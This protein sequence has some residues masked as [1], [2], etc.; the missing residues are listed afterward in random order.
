MNDPKMRV[1]LS[2][3]RAQG[4][5]ALL[6]LLLL[7]LLPSALRAQVGSASLSGVVQDATGAIISGASVIAHNDATGQERK[8]TSNSSGGFTFSA[9]PSGDY[10]ITASEKGFSSSTVKAVH[11]DPGA[12]KALNGIQLEA[13]NVSTSVEVNTEAAGIPLDSGELSSTI[14]AKDLEHLSTVGR[15]AQELEKTLPGF[16]IRSLSNTNSAPDFTIVTIGSPTPYSSNGAPVAGITLK[17]DGAV[18]TDAGNFGANL[19]NINDSFVSE[20]NVQTSNFGVD[21]SNGPVV[22]SAVTKPG[23]SAYHG[24]VYTFARYSALNANDWLSNN[25]GLARPDDRFIYPGG[26]VSGPIPHTKKLTFFAGAEYDAQRNVYA[27]GNSGSAIIHALVPTQAMRNG[28]F[29]Q[30]SLQSYL[31]PNYNN[32]GDINVMPTVGDNGTALANGNLAPYL[33][34]QTM[35]LVNYLLPLPNRPG[36]ATGADGYNW[37][38]QNLVNNNISQYVGRVDYAISPRNTFFARYNFE[39]GKQGQPQVPYYSPQPGNVLGSVNSPGY[40]LEQR[41]SVHS[42]AANYVTIFSPTATNEAFAAL[43]YS[44]TAFV[45]RSNTAV[46]AATAGFGYSAAFANGTT[47]VPQLGTYAAV[48]GLPLALTPDFSVIGLGNTVFQPNVG[49]NFTKVYGKHTVKVGF[50]LQRTSGDGTQTGPNNDTNGVIQNYYFGAAGAEF[51]GYKGTY[52]NGSPAYDGT[53]HYNSG[54]WLG[55]FFEGHIQDYHQISGNP[56]ENLY[57]WTT[58]FYGQDSWRVNKTLLVTG[59]IRFSRMSAWTDRHN[60]GAAVFD[61]SLVNT[62]QSPTTNPYPGLT[63]HAQNSAIQN[64]GTGTPGI[65]V[66]PRVGFAWDVFGTAKTVVRGGYGVYRFHDAT[67]DVQNAF[68]QANGVRTL[69]LQ[70]F[71]GNTLAGIGTL[72]LNPA[73]YG[74]AGGTETSIAPATVYALDPTDHTDPVTNNYSFSISQQFPHNNI[75]QVSYVGNN[76]NSLLNNGTTQSVVLDNI[77]AIPVG[78]L[79]TPTAAAKINALANGHNACSISG[80]T[81]QQIASLDTIYNYAGDKSIQNARPYPEYNQILV[82]HHNNYANYNALQVEFIRNTGKFNYNVNYT[83]S[84]ALGILGSA[85]DFNY[86]AGIDPFNL[87]ANYGPLNFDRSQVLN[88]TYSYQTGRTFENRI[89]GAVANN[90]LI[91]GITNFSSGG[92]MQTGVSYSP[93]FYMQ[94]TIADPT[95]GSYSVMNTTVLGTPDVNLQ[96]TVKCN[97]KSNLGPH[98]YINGSCFGVPSQGTNG[99]SILPYVHGPAFFN[100]DLT[101]ERSFNV[102]HEGNQHIRLRYAA[103]NFLNHPLNSFGTGYANQSTLIVNGTSLANAGVA[104]NTTFGYAPDKLGR[105]ISEISLRYDF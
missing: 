58:D 96:P 62:A 76:S 33:D 66:E 99:Q 50:Y 95:N 70:G 74:N 84:K 67:A 19:M 35:N 73:T 39:Q 2:P 34:K 44:Q 42:A 41:N 49:D 14:S 64:S 105:R 56:K 1:P 46:Q 98:Q 26:Q 60:I 17:L 94:G 15:D 10:D 61:P 79:F 78:T 57:F 102:G 13:G 23:T 80:C 53:P 38:A 48:G 90:W 82:P 55:D 72:H 89:A 28:D 32:Y 37:D 68:L 24:Q 4:P 5:A 86:T 65:F 87:H 71:G 9:L 40:G 92:N 22:V 59:G 100:T 29:S 31:G 8:T 88:F 43:T 83:F 63:W 75:V 85:A 27:Y 69:D 18:L 52:A 51:T 45:P 16:N 91:S 93:S 3:P 54:N 12:S 47:E 81:P 7:L 21:Q 11:L 30:Q 6:A 103:F 20:V 101:L 97:L 36:G 25:S 104:P 77:N